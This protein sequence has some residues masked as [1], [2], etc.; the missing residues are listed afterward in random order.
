MTEAQQPLVTDNMRLV[1]YLANK[2]GET[3]FVKNNFEDLISEGMVGLVKAA[4]AFDP[5]KGVKFATF[6]SRCVTNEMLMYI[7]RNKKHEE[8][9]LLS[10]A[11]GRDSE[12]NELLLSDILADERSVFD[13]MESA[14]EL[15]SLEKCLKSREAAYTMGVD[16]NAIAVH[17]LILDLLLLHRTAY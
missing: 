4:K 11:I 2:L 14:D 1:Y 10:A 17:P 8:N 5:S 9:V 12:G 13:A 6:A 7:R 3:G 15:R 16:W